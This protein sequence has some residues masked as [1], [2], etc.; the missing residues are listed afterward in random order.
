VGKS[1]FSKFSGAPIYWAHRAV[2]FAIAQ[3]P[4][5]KLYSR[6]KQTRKPCYPR[7]NRVMPM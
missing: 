4:C 5:L 6:D 7:K 3:L 1:G 2:V